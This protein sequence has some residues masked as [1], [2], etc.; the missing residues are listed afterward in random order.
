MS[1][2]LVDDFDI[3]L[4]IGLGISLGYIV[5]GLWNKLQGKNWSGK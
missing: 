4:S 3:L 5:G 2:I 1:P